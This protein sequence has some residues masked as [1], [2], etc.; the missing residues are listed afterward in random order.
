MNATQIAVISITLPILF[1]GL[2]WIISKFYAGFLEMSKTV[3]DTMVKLEATI[4]RMDE[5]YKAQMRFC[6]VHSETLKGQHQDITD[7]F[8]EVGGR[9]DKVETKIDEHI[10]EHTIQPRKRTRA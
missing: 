5:Q 8:D 7:K 9:I 6:N 1:G 4:V 3:I 10:K 2:G